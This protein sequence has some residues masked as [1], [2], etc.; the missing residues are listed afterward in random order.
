MELLVS[1]ERQIRKGDLA[2]IC[3]DYGQ[4]SRPMLMMHAQELWNMERILADD[5]SA[6]NSL[7]A[8]LYQGGTMYLMGMQYYERV[9]QFR[10][11]NERIHKVRVVSEFASGLSGLSA[12]RESGQL[13]NNGDVILVLP[14]VDMSFRQTALLGNSTLH[15]DSGADPQQAV[16]DYRALH[17]AEYSAEEHQIINSYFG[18]S[19]SISTIKL[20]QLAQQRATNGNPGVVV[21][22]AQ[23]YQTYATTTYN[24]TA[25]KDHDPALWAKVVDFFRRSAVSNLNVAMVTPGSIVNDSGTY[26]GMGVLL[27]SPYFE[28]AALISPNLNG[29]VA[30]KN[31]SD[32]ALGSPNSVNQRLSLNGPVFS[33]D[34]MPVDASN[35]IL[36]LDVNAGFHTANVADF[37]NQDY[38]VYSS[39]HEQMTA[40]ALNQLSI[41]S[42]G[43][44]HDNYAQMRL[45]EAGDMGFLGG[46]SYGLSQIGTPVSDPVHAV[47]GE[48]YVDAV[49]LTLPG[50]M[51]LQIRRNYSSHNVADNQFGYGWKLNYMPFLSLNSSNTVIF[52]AEPDGSVVA[53]EQTGTNANV[54]L[55]DASLNPQ[56]VNRTSQGIGST[57]NLFRARI[58]KVVDGGNTFYHLFHPNGSERIFK[59]MTFSGSVSSTRPYLVEWYD[60][61]GNFFLFE[62]GND[63]TQADYG[64]VRRIQ[65]C[66]GS[67][68]G[69]YYDV[70]GHVTE[71]YTGDGRR[72]R[73]GYDGFG[74]LVKVTLPDA[75]VEEYEYEHGSLSVTNGSNVTVSPYSTHLLIREAKPDGRLLVNAYDEHRRVTNQMATAGVDLNPIR[76]ATFVYS[77]NFVFTN[78]F[79]NTI[80][81]TTFVYD[82][83]DHL[84]RHDYT[85]GLITKV[86]D[87]LGAAVEQHWYADDATPPGH[88]RSLWKKQDQRGLWTEYQYDA[89]GNVTNAIVTGD[90]TGDGQTTNAVTTTTYNTNNLP[91]VI[92]DALGNKVEYVYN[93]TYPFLREQ[94]IQYAGATPIITNRMTYYNVTNTFTSGGVSYTNL[95]FGLLQQVVRAYDAPDAATTAWT[96]DGRG[97]LTQ[98]IQYTGTGDPNVTN[99]F[100]Y[101]DRGELV[102]TADSAGR[103]VK[104]DFDALGRPKLRE[105]YEA[106]QTQPLSWAYSHFN[107]NGELTWSDGPR[108]DPEDYVW[109]DYDGAGRQTVEIRWR[110][111]AKEDG[112]GVEAPTGDALFATTFYEYDGFSNL[113]NIIDPRGNYMRRKFD[114][115]GRL[116]NEVFYSAAG[117]ALATNAYAYEPGG[118]LSV[119]TNALGGVAKKYYT[120]SGQPLREESADGSTNQ[121]RYYLDGRLK[122]EIQR[123]GAYWETTYDDAN[124]RTTRV[125]Y[126]TNGT[127]LATNIT[128][129]DRRGNVVRTVDAAGFA[130]TNVFDGLDRLKIWLGPLIST[131]PPE[132]SPPSPGGGSAANIQQVFTNYFDAAG[133]VT[134]NVNALGEKTI[135]YTDALGR[136]TRTEVRTS[137]NVLVRETGTA[138]AQNHH[139]LTVTNGSGSTAILSTTY[140]DNDGHNVLSLSYP[141]ANVTHFTLRDFDLTG[142]LLFEGRYART[143]STQTQFTSALFSYD[144]LNRLVQKTDRDG[145]ITTFAYNPAGNLTNQV[146]PG[147]LIWNAA[148]SSAGQMLTN[149]NASSGGSVVR[150]N[151]YTYYG[152][153]SGWMGLLETQTDARGVVCTHTYD[154]WLRPLT[155]IYSGPLDE[156]D[157][158]TAWLHDVRGLL[159]NVVERFALTNTGPE[160]SI[161]RE[162]NAYGQLTVEQVQFGPDILS[163][164]LSSSH[165]YN[166]AGR[167]AAAGFGLFGYNF[168]WRAD[169][170]LSRVD[171]LYGDTTYGY[172]TAGLLTNRVSGVRD[173]RIN[174]RDGM[175]RPLTVETK[176]NSVTQLTETL[177]YTGDG[178]IASHNMARGDFT[179]SRAYLY[180]NLSRR[181]TQESL[182]LSSSSTWTNVFSYDAGAAQGAGVLTRIAQDATGG[183]EWT[184]HMDE[185]LRVDRETNNVVRRLA[186]GRVNMQPGYGFATTSIELN[187]RPVPFLTL[188]NGD[189]NWP[190]RWQAQI[191]LLPGTHTLTASVIHPS[192]LFTNTTTATFTNNA[193]DQTTLSYYSEGQL[194]QRVWKNSQGQTN[195]VQTFQWDARGRLYRFTERDAN[196]HGHDWSALY[197]AFGRRWYT[198]TLAITNNVGVPSELKQF[199]QH[200]DPLAEFLEVG[201]FR[202]GKWA[203]K[204]HGPDL[205][206]VYGGMNGTGGWDAV[207]DGPDKFYPLLSD[208]RG[209]ILAAFDPEAGAVSWNKSRITAYG[210][211]AERRPL[212]LGEGASLW[213]AGSWRGRYP[214][215]SGLYN[216]GAR[217]YDPV[218]GRF[219]SPDPLG[220]DSDASLYSF[221]NGDPVDYFD[222]DGRLA[223]TVGN[224]L[225]RAGS[226]LL[227]AINVTGDSIR[228][229]SL[230]GVFG[231]PEEFGTGGSKTYQYYYHNASHVDANQVAYEI[232]RDAIWNTV[233]VPLLG[234]THAAA[235]TGTG[236]GN[237]DWNGAQDAWLNSLLLG[238]AARTPE[239]PV[240]P[241]EVGTYEQL[242]SRSIR[243]DRLD[244][245]HQPSHAS[246]VARAEAELGRRLTEAEAR[247]IRDQG[248]A[249]AVPEQWHRTQSPTYG[250]RNTAA[251]IKADA[252]DPVAAATRDSAAMVNGATAAQRAAAEAAAAAVRRRTKGK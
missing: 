1:E 2:A 235:A 187:G 120:A 96:H 117:A 181:L 101:N 79:T 43:S 83:F 233:D 26:Q 234:L 216:L 163:S 205:N 42:Q 37:A 78:S 21:L 134:T 197:D 142:N 127:A 76:N 98:Q 18:Q 226:G 99:T 58:E 106:G 202:D 242:R 55:P 107:P 201:V 13:P 239:A 193:V 144:G 31:L 191:E 87:P 64:E 138:Y 119:A 30:G 28:D 112:S 67:Y 20:L 228:W 85:N 68:L 160:V 248:T 208:V 167:R 61:R 19:G 215:L 122:R 71:A 73:Y 81:G 204:V 41:A 156:Q 137:G 88:P 110:S 223:S 152:T 198:Y 203:W 224:I 169:G 59:V 5:P 29:G 243:G 39:F 69:F 180:A 241:Y 56:M 247:Q 6:T 170:A 151:G 188:A 251:R 159:T 174:S 116:T 168:E 46:V 212:S 105:V 49:D 108:F 48:F 172:D 34:L 139:G 141:A 229:L 148:Y 17:L 161:R 84:T 100:F 182:N 166:S 210:S 74:D 143:N 126:T 150:A 164:S 92:T 22:N 184:A 140:T 3:L 102:E 230:N 8:D 244:L 135:T 250:G 209:N 123:N 94:V 125:F 95:A 190:T 245:D 173:T 179:D 27:W 157:M 24:G 52:A 44:L 154:H 40:N 118:L 10:E 23:N 14:R 89:A 15:P 38:Y 91:L 65:S 60:D 183:A 153:G 195:R 129:M 12:K 32:A 222:P 238:F 114:A 194:T 252:A 121:W 130:S 147:G 16:L 104:S 54:W 33:L 97:Y 214:E 221:A 217:Y 237:G 4:V 162:Y 75:S 145:A 189:T 158:I 240:A 246:N 146:V 50:P 149:W 113:T 199:L 51:P 176:A 196:N 231:V 82:F 177:A 62:Y 213:E 200:Y 232:S 249:V 178:L 155:N 77:N 45:A 131:T 219:L 57:A 80:T 192:K 227:E 132:G 207:V 165:A 9:N 66:N 86:T 175:G 103:K 128:E 111:Q 225:K 7:S 218:A 53:Y 47:T 136:V 25:L 133:I 206:G 186:Y 211:V 124:R 185:H 72:I 109:R 36:A 70:F 236:A 35:R 171:T 90:L 115:L 220:H 11:F 93:A 63:V